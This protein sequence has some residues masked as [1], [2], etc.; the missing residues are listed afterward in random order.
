MA[1]RGGES[2]ERKKS[3]IIMGEEGRMEIQNNGIE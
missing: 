2:T 3:I 1:Q